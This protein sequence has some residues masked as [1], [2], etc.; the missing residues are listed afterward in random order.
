[1]EELRRTLD[2]VGIRIPEDRL[3]LMGRYRDML[4][5]WNTRMD[6]TNVSE[7]DTVRRHFLDS[8]LPLR[9]KELFPQGARIVDVG[10]GAGFPGLPLAIARA[11]LKLT[12]LEAQ[13]KRCGFLTAVKEALGLENVEVLQ[14][15]AEIAGQDGRYREQFDRAAARAVA[16]LNLLCEYLLPL[17]KVGGAAICWKGPG[18]RE[19]MED[20]EAAANLLGGR[21]ERIAEIGPDD[22]RHTLA[23]IR[24]WEKTV[25][26]YPRK[27]GI[28]AKRPLKK[29]KT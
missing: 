27:N 28:P 17:V 2:A 14:S 9:E 18:V 21:I 10:S 29:T 8:L 25:P 20:G 13:G 15:R 7:Q 22:T 1:M 6:L 16:P 3:A 5:D 4:L 12:L 19:E 26:Q 24:K 11:D 23:V